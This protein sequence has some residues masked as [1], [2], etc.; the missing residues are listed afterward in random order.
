MS[1]K[2]FKPGDLLI[3]EYN[4]ICALFLSYL[5]ACPYYDNIGTCTGDCPTW[6]DESN[7]VYCGE[8]CKVLYLDK[9][10][11]IVEETISDMQDYKLLK[12]KTK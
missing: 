1:R 4:L 7:R 12:R 5:P 3:N 11:R 10:G 6:Y 2:R 9:L 8:A